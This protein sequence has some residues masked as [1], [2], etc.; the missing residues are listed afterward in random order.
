MPSLKHLLWIAAV[1]WA[2][3]A[4]AQFL[5]LD[6][7]GDGRVERFQLVPG[8]EGMTLQIENTGGGVIDIEDIVPPGYDAG[9]AFDAENRLSLTVRLPETSGLQ[10][11]MSIAIGFDEADYRITAITY[12]VGNPSDPDR[13]GLCIVD[14]VRGEVRVGLA[15]APT[16]TR[17]ITPGLPP[18]RAA[19]LR[20]IG[21]PPADCAPLP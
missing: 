16:E 8:P 19:A 13:G 6:L 21:L 3:A 7:N 1:I 18:L 9:L 10:R 5:S 14:P 15:G 20:A 17:R 12:L 2:T 11:E 4:Q